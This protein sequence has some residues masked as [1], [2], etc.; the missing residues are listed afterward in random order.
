MSTLRSCV[1]PSSRI[2][3]SL[4]PSPCVQR[5][6]SKHQ[7]CG[8]VAE[9]PSMRARASRSWTA[10]GARRGPAHALWT[11]ECLVPSQ[12]RLRPASHP[13]TSPPHPR[14]GRYCMPFPPF[15]HRTLVSLSVS[16]ALGLKL[17]WTLSQSHD[18][19]D[20]SLA[21]A[22]HDRGLFT[23]RERGAVRR[24]VHVATRTPTGAGLGLDRE[25]GAYRADS[26]EY[27]A[28]STHA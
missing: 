20:R 10:G 18:D 9:D 3:H 4:D 22:G 16:H 15:E 21:H 7:T 14:D 6:P 8:S 24:S 27:R 11:M 1:S 2:L 12:L 13:S 17:T 28:T 23:G 19:R 25:R 26:S 5:R